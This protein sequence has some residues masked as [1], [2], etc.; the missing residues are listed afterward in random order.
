MGVVTSIR[1]LRINAVTII[2]PTE[3]VQHSIYQT[4]TYHSVFLY[5]QKVRKFSFFVLSPWTYYRLSDFTEC[6]YIV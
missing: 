5:P 4:H 3:G 1:L 2:L 6:Q